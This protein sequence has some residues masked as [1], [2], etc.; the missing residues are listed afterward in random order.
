M[1][2]TVETKGYRRLWFVAAQR[3]NWAKGVIL[4]I[5]KS[6]PIEFEWKGD[7]TRVLLFNFGAPLRPGLG[8]RGTQP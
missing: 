4:E 7:R 2:E 6:A 3:T 5:E 8:E 1:I